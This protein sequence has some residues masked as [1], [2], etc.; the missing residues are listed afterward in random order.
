M[1]QWFDTADPDQRA[2]GLTAAVTA[3]RRGQVVGLPLDTTYGLAADAFSELGVT[4]L[5]AARGR[6]D[7]T[8]PVMVPRIGTV[9]GIAEVSEPAR[10]LMRAFWPGALTLVLRAQPSLNWSIGA[11]RR[12]VAVRMPLHPVAL[13]LLARTGPLGVVGAGA[14]DASSA[15]PDSKD[16]QPAVVLDAGELP[17][18][19]A[20]AVVDLT[21][22]E[23]ALLRAG[24]LDP[25]EL[26]GVWA[27]ARPAAPL[28]P[29]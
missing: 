5:R 21:G 10:A 11:D 14:S 28:P 2:R 24:P 23:P 6:P 7:L 19:A 20:S 1:T 18:G 16:E 25:A 27:A 8:V 22:A 4:R 13:E 12:R 29:P 15:F 3:L 26:R 17:G 9:A